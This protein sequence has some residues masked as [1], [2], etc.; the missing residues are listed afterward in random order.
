MK[1]EITRVKEVREEVKDHFTRMRE[2][3]A[4]YLTSFDSLKDEVD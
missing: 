2:D 4:V 3:R 1:A